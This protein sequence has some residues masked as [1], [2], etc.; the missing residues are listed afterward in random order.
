ML[1]LS[2]PIILFM[3]VLVWIISI[4][5]GWTLIFYADENALK[6]KDGG[7]ID[8]TDALWYISYTMFTVGNG[9]AS[10]KTDLY[11]VLSSVVSL[12]GMLMVTLSVTYILQV[13]TAVVDKRSFANQVISIGRTAEEFVSE[14]WTGEGFGAIELQ[15]VS[16][17]GKLGELTEQHLAYP[18]LNY[19]HAAK[20]ENSVATAVAIYD[21]AMTIIA[22]AI[23]EDY[24]PP[25]TVLTS[26]RR[27]VDSYLQML[28]TAFIKPSDSPPP[29]PNLIHL[30]E[31]NIPVTQE[32][33]FQEAL[34]EVDKRRRLHF[35]SIINDAWH[36]PKYK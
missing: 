23:P 7:P 12:T 28:N 27:T 35:G 36:W 14:Q 2:G 5:I 10:P 19:Y 30:H 20:Y 3:T 33:H 15:M 29:P 16:L 4:D 18:I 24:H 34:K 26:G 6:A 31:K 11:Q 17:N 21:D 8:F 9:D 32:T 25:T 1:S 22:E 13:I